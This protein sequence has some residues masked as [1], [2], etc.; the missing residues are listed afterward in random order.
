[1][2]KYLMGNMIFFLLWKPNNMSKKVFD[3]DLAAIRKGKVK[4]IL[5]KPAYVGICIIHLS[6]VLMEKFYSF[7]IKTKYGNNSRLLFTDIGSLIYEI[8]AKDAYDD[9]S[10]DK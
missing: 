9:F 1:M 8:A 3:N 5:N 6:K 7:Y 2:K 4:L 10:K